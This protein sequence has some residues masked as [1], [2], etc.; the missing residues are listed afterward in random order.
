[1]SAVLADGAIR[2]GF[3]LD[4]TGRFVVISIAVHA[5]LLAWKIQQPV[6]PPVLP[7]L[8]IRLTPPSRPVVV[9]PPALPEAPRPAARSEAPAVKPRAPT[10]APM[11]A[12]KPIPVLSTAA[13]AM[14]ANTVPP[15]V[16]VPAPVVALATAAVAPTPAPKKAL[17]EKP[18]ESVAIRAKPA[19]SVSPAGSANELSAYTHLYSRW[20]AHHRVYPR[21]AQMRGWQGQ[22]L[23]H[24]RVA[25]KGSVIDMVI[26]R[27]SGF[28]VLDQQAL[29][30]VR[31][32]DPL[33][34]LP[35][36]L[37]EREFSL[38]VPIVFRLE[39]S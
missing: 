33:P 11:P 2:Y 12:V 32:A 37:A 15:A 30:M 6:V 4:R 14:P 31:Q 18:A 24:V 26:S 8:E 28:D 9:L 27:S 34:D 16:A 35:A 20:L 7:R 5:A 10:P 29:D 13:K 19:E 21:I 36:S 1:M 22:V 23:V 3:E 39:Q 17:E 25:R 38:D